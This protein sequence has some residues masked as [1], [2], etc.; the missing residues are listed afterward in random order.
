LSFIRLNVRSSVLFPE[1]V[2][3]SSAVIRLRWKSVA[4]LLST[5][6]VPKLS[7][8][9]TVLKLTPCSAEDPFPDA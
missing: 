4:M 1:P 5:A 2:G 7:V 3:P 6:R 8:R 9:S